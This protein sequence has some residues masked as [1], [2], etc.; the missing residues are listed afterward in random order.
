MSADDSASVPDGWDDEVAKYTADYAWNPNVKIETTRLTSRVAKGKTP[1]VIVSLGSFNPV[2]KMHT[3]LM[4][5]CR[6]AVNEMDGFEVIGG[7]MSPTHQKY[8][9]PSLAPMHD[10]LN[11]LCLALRDSSWVAP[12]VWECS[13][14]EWTRTRVALEHFGAQL[15]A[16]K[17]AVGEAEPA[18]GLVKVLMVCGGDLLQ[19]FVLFKKNGERIW[20]KPDV[21][22]ILGDF[23]VVCVRRHGTDEDKV[24][25]DNAELNDH[26][27]NIVLVHPDDLQNTVSSTR[28]RLSL[29]ATLESSPAEKR[30]SV[31]GLVDPAV[32]AYMVDKKLDLL[33]QWQSAP[34]SPVLM[35]NRMA[36]R[37]DA[38]F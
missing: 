5:S 13:Q 2:T 29:T 3:S 11:T 17:V 21:A 32:A 25:A 31:D 15:A 27:D 4:D 30:A 18:E 19:S 23:G 9:K 37:G 10:R 14:T 26:K 35:A 24:I 20:H 28:V 1:V 8:G 33:P 34:T 12:E 16:W 38:L 36:A 22:A 7:F 6:K